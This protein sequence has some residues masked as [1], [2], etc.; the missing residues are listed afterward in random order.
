MSPLLWACVVL[1]LFGSI[2]LLV[3]V[4]EPGPWIGV[5]VVAMASFV[6]GAGVRQP[7]S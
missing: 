4:G 5:T 6:L 3:G 2:M 7:R 1:M